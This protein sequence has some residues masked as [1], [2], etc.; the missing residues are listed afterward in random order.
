MTRLR[1]APVQGSGGDLV[2]LIQSHQPDR[3]GSSLDAD[4][5]W[6]VVLRSVAVGG[7]GLILA[8]TAPDVAAACP[9][10][11]TSPTFIDNRENSAL[12]QQP[13]SSGSST[14]AVMATLDAA[15]QIREVLAALGLNKSLLATVL[16]V[17]R[18]T[19]YGWL[20][21]TEPTPANADRIDQICGLLRD[22]G[23]STSAPLNTR[24][25]RRAMAPEAKPLLELLSEETIENDRIAPLLQQARELSQAAADRRHQREASLRDFG[26]E[27]SPDDEQRETIGRNVTLLNWPK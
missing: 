26:Y 13:S 9:R 10:Y 3:T 14:L 2:A 27:E 16:R 11:G 1:E 21:G 4:P 19:L 22:S 8:G 5:I 25:V 15:E 18:P 24:F 20:E 6:K 12:V 17:S 23:I 7:T